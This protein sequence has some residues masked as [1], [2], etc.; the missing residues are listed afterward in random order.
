MS[1]IIVPDSDIKAIE[2]D[3]LMKQNDQKSKIEAEIRAKIEMENKLKQLEEEKQKLAQE[4]E[5][6]KKETENVK[7][8]QEEEAK[9]IRLEMD[10]FKK[11]ME[12]QQASSKGFV[13]NNNPYAQPVK[14]NETER[15][16][17]ELFSNPQKLKEVETASMEAFYG[18]IGAKA[19]K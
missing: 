10:E 11:K 8:Q 13:P 3:I 15:I 5:N 2:R 18:Y 16:K 19:P 4:I 6:A 7:K 12:E 9:K 14:V 1:D 17:N